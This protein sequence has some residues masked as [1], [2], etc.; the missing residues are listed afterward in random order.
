[1]LIIV[2][3]KV[4]YSF[5][6]NCIRNV[7]ISLLDSKRYDSQYKCDKKQYIS[8]DRDIRSLFLESEYILTSI[9]LEVSTLSCCEA[10]LKMNNLLFI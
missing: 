1:M 7:F 4:L 2:I 8:L 6:L 3:G 10:T 9:N 5:F